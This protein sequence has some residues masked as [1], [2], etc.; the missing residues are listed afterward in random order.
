MRPSPKDRARSLGWL[1]AATNAGVAIGP[2]LG[3]WALR[4]GAHPISLGG[5]SVL[6]GEKAPGLLAAALCLLNMVFAWHLPARIAGGERLR[7][8]TS[9]A[10][11][12]PSWTAVMRVVTNPDGRR[13]G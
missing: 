1:S 10:C 3:S 8:P 6:L 12:A 9:R 2:V 13:R 4:A 7:Q 5:H 11:R